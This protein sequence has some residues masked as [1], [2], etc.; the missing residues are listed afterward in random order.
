MPST[1]PH[2]RPPIEQR[3]VASWRRYRR[4]WGARVEQDLDEELAFHVEMRV[5]DYQARGLGEPEAR[6]VARS[7]LGDLDVARDACLAIVRRRERRMHR[8]QLWDA[9][10]QDVVYALRTLGRQKGWTT[11]AVITLALG[12]GANTA[13]FSVVHSLLVRP[14]PYPGA[15]RVVLPWRA[16]PSSGMMLSPSVEMLDGWRTHARSIEALETYATNEVTLTGLAEPEVLHAAAIGPTFPRFAGV[17]LLLGRPFVAEEVRSGGPAVVILGE[18]LWRQRFGGAP[19][20]V[21]KTIHLD[22]APYTIVGV[23]P[24]ELRLPNMLQPHTD[25]W[26]P[27]VPRPDLFSAAGIA[28]LRPGVAPAAAER[29]LDSLTARLGLNKSTAQAGFVARL[30]APRDAVGFRESLVLL[31][32]AV[33][34]LLLIAC[35]NVAHLLLARGAARQHEL[36]V[37]SALGASRPRLARQLLTESLL[38]AVGGFVGGIAVGWAGLRAIVALRPERL[39]QL[40]RAEMDGRVLVAMGVVALVTGLAFGLVGALHTL[41]AG[42]GQSLKVSA[43]G[44]TAT[45]RR[46]RLRSALVVSEMAVSAMLLV[47]AVLLIRSVI[48]LQQVDPGFDTRHLYGMRVELPPARYPS[49]AQQRAFV[50]QLAERARRLPGVAAVTVSAT[51]P[52]E[53]SFMVG[54]IET[55]EGAASVDGAHAGY[56]AANWV[57]PDYFRTLGIHLVEGRAFD[58]GSDGRDEA[59]VNE[60]MARRLWA[61]RSAVGGRFRF[62]TTT[63]GGR[64]PPFLTVV[65]VA[66]GTVTHD[67]GKGSAEPLVYMPVKDEGAV[68]TTSM[69]NATL[70]VRMADER[71]PG[72]ALRRLSLALDP[73]IAPTPATSVDASL[74]ASIASQRF[75][76]LLLTIFAGLAVALAAIGLYGVI[77]FGVAQRTREIGIRI[78]LGASR[79]GIARSVVSGGVRLSVL[80][81][82]LGLA[83]AAWGTRL[84]AASLYGVDARDPLSYAAGAALLL[85]VSVLACV[86]PMRRAMAVDPL[87]AMRSE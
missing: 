18:R 48:N 15:E 39:D 11:V 8:A 69:G 27:F 67:L 2:E 30:M 24:E 83:G 87:V 32:G 57:T 56:T 53:V 41:R 49:P 76:M 64:E 22:A 55:P 70:V 59:I 58:A 65:G 43:T 25:V 37:R 47:G 16:M 85:A 68:V 44:G 23:A 84:I 52:P 31:W 21:G 40:A 79:R 73:N 72:P 82:V 1:D 10:R 13:V 86:M 38:L 42:A 5:R 12:I 9:L 61:G 4:F 66:A 19:D 29:E 50:E 6:A 62:A 33:G 36:A 17:R 26:L 71:H 28:R 46:Q 81:L 75:T 78:A 51:I 60:A 45:R 34:L 35:A 74:A 77:A 80:G 54:A 20:V 63:T 7:R 3:R 14:L